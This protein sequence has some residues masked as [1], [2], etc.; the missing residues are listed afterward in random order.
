MDITHHF[1]STQLETSE[2]E[3]N[4]IKALYDGVVRS[5]LKLPMA[6]RALG[7]LGTVILHRGSRASNRYLRIG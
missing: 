6:A 1:L 4:R 7:P 3:T 2:E 5:L